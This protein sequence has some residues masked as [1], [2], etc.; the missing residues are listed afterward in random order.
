MHYLKKYWKRVSE[1]EQTPE[2]IGFFAALDAMQSTSPEAVEAILQEYFDQRNSLKMIAS[3]NYA[4]L[5][6]QLSMGGNFLTDKYSEGS[7]GKRFYAGCE[8]VDAIE[9]KAVDLAK[10]LYGAEHAYVQPHSGADANL[11]AFL[12]ILTVRVQEPHLQYKG[13]KL[14]ELSSE[15]FADLRSIMLEQKMLGMSLSSGGHLTHGYRH[16]ISSKLFLSS[17]YEVDPKTGW[18]DY[19]T[20]EEQVVREKPL[21]FVVGYSSYTRKIDFSRMRQIADRVGATLLVD[22][23]HFSG[24][25]AGKVFTGKYNPVPFAD[26]VTS[27]THKTLRG[28]RG[29]MILCKKEYQAA[30][31]KGCPLVMGG[32]LPQNIAAKA[33]AFQEALSPSFAV[34]SQNI[35]DN[36][37]ALARSFTEKGASLLTG[38]TDN[39]MVLVDTHTSYGL[40]GKA[41]EH[42]LSLINIRVNRNAIPE[43]QNGPWYT[44][45]IRLG[46]PAL[47]TR[48]MGKE[49]MEQ[50]VGIVDT[51]LRATTPAHIEGRPSK[52]EV[53]IEA[54]ILRYC[55]EEV[56]ALVG[57]YP[58]YPE[59]HLNEEALSKNAKLCYKKGK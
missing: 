22:M 34:Y 17:F 44:S 39:H 23:A 15:E 37:R 51:L 12:A 56:N 58:L 32:P 50:I 47:T 20:L 25:V 27:T 30:V 41:A 49:Q 2:A 24:L 46:T 6:V 26:I 18:I 13:K 1:K 11:I 5:R 54:S 42:A 43:D 9:R 53:R 7:V 33:V 16:N 52:G 21:I 48:G 10:Q 35:V 3:E 4:S 14:N 19:D 28:P 29:G 59:L 36:A 31:D 57:R 8:N 45:G 38:G 55:R 40:T